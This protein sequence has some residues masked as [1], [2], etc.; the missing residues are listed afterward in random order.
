MSSHLDLLALGPLSTL[1][2]YQGYDIN[3]FPFYTIKKDGKRSY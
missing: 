2:K 1:L 3:G